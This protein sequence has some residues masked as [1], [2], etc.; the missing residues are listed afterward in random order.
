MAHLLKNKHHVTDPVWHL[1]LTMLVALTLQ[2]ALPDEF[3][4]IAPAAIPVAEALLLILLSFTTPKERIFKSLARRLN[5]FLLILIAS[6]AN[7]YALVQVVSKLLQSGVTDGRALILTSINI[8]VTN[9]IIFALWYW[10]M[11]GGGPGER[12]RIAKYEQDF[13]FPQHQHEDYRHPEWKPTFVDYL[14]VSSTNA[15][16]FGPADTKPLTRRTKMLMLIQATISLITVALVAARAVGI[17][18]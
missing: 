2:L 12:Q 3:A 6:I 1:Q 11:D 18:N 8:F 5:V 15:M 17:L 14:Y 7:A 13:L 10:E 9:I 16:T 4:F